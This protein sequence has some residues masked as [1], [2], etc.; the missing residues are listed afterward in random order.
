MMPAAPG[1]A[2]SPSATARRLDTRNS[3]HRSAVLAAPVMRGLPLSP[4][5]FIS[6]ISLSEISFTL[7]ALT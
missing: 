3:T 7:V 5:W 6:S 4:G 2:A 1:P